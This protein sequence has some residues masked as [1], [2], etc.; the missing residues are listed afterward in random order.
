MVTSALLDLPSGAAESSDFSG[1]SNVVA[2]GSC[3]SSTVVSTT[4]TAACTT[5]CDGDSIICRCF[6]VTKQEVHDAVAS[7]NA[8]TISQLRCE[9][10]A[11][12]GCMACLCKIKQLLA[13]RAAAIAAEAGEL[14]LAAA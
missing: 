2:V 11:A 7:G 6:K 3:T 12:S 10:G 5:C 8:R 4:A 14:E 9:T 13:E 1:N